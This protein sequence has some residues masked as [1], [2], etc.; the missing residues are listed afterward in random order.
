MKILVVGS[1]GREHAII[2]NLKEDKRVKEIY[3]AKGNGGISEVATLVDIEETNIKE[4]INFCKDKKI[5]LTIVGPEVPLTLGIVD[6]FEK[7]GLKIFGPNKACANLEGS[8]SFCKDF[9]IRH[10]IPT[11]KYKEYTNFNNA[12]SE[13]DDFGYPV[14]IKADGLCAGKGVLI[15][16]DKNEATEAL[17]DI[18]NSKVFKSAGDKVI[19]EEFLEGIETSILAFVDKN[20]IIPMVSAKDHK[21]IF[22]GET[23]LNTGGMGTISPSNIYTDSLKD[24]IQKEI[25]DKTLNGFKKDNLDFR[26]ILFV[27]LMITKD[28]AKVLEFNVRFGDP[29]AQVVLSRLETSLV[30]IIDSILNDNLDEINIKYSDK[31]AVCVILSSGG[32]PKSYEVDK[33]IKGLNEL[34]E[35]VLVFHSGTKLVDG[36]YYTNGGRVLGITI[37][38]ES[39]KKSSDR[40]YENIKRISFDNMHFRTDIGR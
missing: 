35:D 20:N 14:V 11:A 19:V 28:G 26:G 8:K 22:D 6:E 17:D 38:D 33:E 15:C 2:C 7:E 10:K 31:K 29:E 18:M 36:K 40:V 30:D 32:Y 4:L 13:I 39:I 16:N 3:C 12:I 27:G 5:D 21:K 25:L 34:D 1:G 37:L 23:G 24:E 9:L